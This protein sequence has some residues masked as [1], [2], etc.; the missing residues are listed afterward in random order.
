MRRRSKHTMSRGDQP[1]ASLEGAER[2]VDRVRAEAAESEGGLGHGCPR[3]VV[4]PSRWGWRRP[5]GR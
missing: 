2:D 3:S 5:G 4:R 1:A